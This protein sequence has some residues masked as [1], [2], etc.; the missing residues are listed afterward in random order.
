MTG[1]SFLSQLLSKKSGIIDPDR[2][3]TILGKER[4]DIGRSDGDLLTVAYPVRAIR[5]DNYLYSRNFKPNRWPVGDP[6]YG[7][8]N[9]DDSPTKQYL[10]ELEESHSDYKYFEMAFGFRPE[11][12][13]YDM[14][15]DPECITNLA[16]DK[17]YSEL[18]EQLWT[19]L[20]EQL[21]KQ[22]GPRILGKGEIF[23]Y[24]PYSKIYKEKDAYGEKFVD[25]IKKHEDFI[26][27]KLK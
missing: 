9:C 26:S 25:P 14:V 21:I 5:N 2:S 8:R 11:E 19:Q 22:E 23:D 1:H 3:F 7:Y 20:K 6:E 13:L 18:K 16:N 17:N 10:V 4:H 24:Y 15:R 27:S 12:E